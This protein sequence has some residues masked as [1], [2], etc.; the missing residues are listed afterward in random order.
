MGFQDTEPYHNICK[1]TY[2]VF[3]SNLWSKSSSS[4]V[5]D[6]QTAILAWYQTLERR[7]QCFPLYRCQG[8]RE[9]FIF[10]HVKKILID[11]LN[12]VF[13]L[14]MW[15]KS[16]KGFFSMNENVHITFIHKTNKKVKY[17][18]GLPYISLV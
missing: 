12:Y 16:Y 15:V 13:L 5:K 4:I 3:L 2:L 8:F 14:G 10:Y 7:V 1:Q 17:I 18:N 9:V 11:Y 6:N